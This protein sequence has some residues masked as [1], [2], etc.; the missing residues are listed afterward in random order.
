MI[1][2]SGPFSVA[3]ERPGQRHPLPLPDRQVGAADELGTQH[4]LVAA[5]ERLEECVGA[6]VPR[7]ISDRVEVVDRVEPAK[8]NIVARR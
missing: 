7:S 2:L 3:D 8:P 6:G 5:R 4:R 1:A